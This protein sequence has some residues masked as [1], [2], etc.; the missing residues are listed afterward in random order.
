FVLLLQLLG[1]LRD[2]LFNLF[3]HGAKH[4]GE[5]RFGG[6]QVFLLGA[7]Q[8]AALHLVRLILGGFFFRHLLCLIEVGLLQKKVLLALV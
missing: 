7:E 2:E 1:S 8:D 5:R 3:I 4:G 6:N